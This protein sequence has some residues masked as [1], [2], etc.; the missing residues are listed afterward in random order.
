[1]TTSQQDEGHHGK[2]SISRPTR[3]VGSCS[4]QSWQNSVAP[5]ASA[6][7]S[8]GRPCPGP[9]SERLTTDSAL[10]SELLLRGLIVEPLSLVIAKAAGVARASVRGATTICLFCRKIVPAR[11]RPDPPASGPIRP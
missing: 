9:D 7:Q 6:R 11:L 3:A 2:R 1:M 5:R 4:L 10:R 8:V